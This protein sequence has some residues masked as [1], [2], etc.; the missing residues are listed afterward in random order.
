A[1]P[2]LNPFSLPWVCIPNSSAFIP[3]NPT[4]LLENAPITTINRKAMCMFAPGGIVDFIS[5]G[6]LHVKTS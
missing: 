6:Q 3:T 4:T 2:T 5:S 1:T